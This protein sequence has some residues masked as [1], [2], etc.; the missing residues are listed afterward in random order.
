ML[1]SSH[2]ARKIYVHGNYVA[3][4]PTVAGLEIEKVVCEIS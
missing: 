2:A 1:V 4:T 3:H